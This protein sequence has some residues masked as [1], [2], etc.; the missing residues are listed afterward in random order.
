MIKANRVL[1][2]FYLMVMFVSISIFSALLSTTR[3]I[4]INDHIVN[5]VL[6][7]VSTS[8]AGLIFYLLNPLSLGKVKD[9]LDETYTAS[10]EK[11]ID[12]LVRYPFAILPLTFTTGLA[13]MF[14]YLLAGSSARIIEL[15]GTL[16]SLGGIAVTFLFV[17]IIGEI[18]QIYVFK[19]VTNTSASKAIRKLNV[20]ELKSIYIPIKYKL[21]GVYSIISIAAFIIVAYAV[22]NNA[23]R[24]IK[25]GL[26][27]DTMKSASLIARTIDQNPNADSILKGIAG[28][29]GSTYR[30]YLYNLH[31][32]TLKAYSRATPGSRV[33][34]E[35]NTENMVTDTQNKQ[36]IFS[37]HKPLMIDGSPHLLVI[38]ARDSLYR[39]LLYRFVSNMSIAGIFILFIV[40]ITTFL[41]SNDI[42]S[43]EK[44]LADYSASLSENKLSQTPGLFSTDELGLI[45]LNL[46]T[47]MQTFKESRVRTNENVSGMNGMIGATFKNIAAVRS[48][49][50]EQSKHTDD[51]FGIINSI[52]DIARQIT[53]LS[54]PF[55]E[56]IEKDSETVFHAIQ[57]NRE[58]KST[59]TAASTR[60]TR[61]LKLIEKDVNAYEDMK[62]TINK[63]KTVL[64][65]VDSTTQSY[66]S[67]TD[68]L[69][70][71]LDGFSGIMNDIKKSNGN[72]I[73][74][75]K[76]IEVIVNETQSIAEGVLS[77]LSSF[78]SH[79]QQSDEMLGMINNVAERTNLLS[80]N[81]F[82]LASSPQ[83]EGNNFRVVAEEIKRLAGRART[84]SKD[85]SD[86]ITKVRRNVDEVSSGIKD[87]NGMFTGLKQSMSD[88]NSMTQRTGELS[89]SASDIAA[90][91]IGGITG[92]T[93][94]RNAGADSSLNAHSMEIV[95]KL[96]ED[97]GTTLDSLKGIGR[98]FGQIKD[99]LINLAEINNAH[100]TTLL[101]ISNAV[102]N[103]KTFIG[104]INDSLA[105]D[106]K[107]QVAY[108]SDSAKEL[109][110]HIRNNEQNISDLDTIMN[111][112]IQELDLLKENINLVIV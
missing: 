84:G 21:I 34:K 101:S 98:V 86:Y 109:I 87:I 3:I 15:N 107:E 58:T 33:I 48:T 52:K 100:D 75:T 31:D 89:N 112:L 6:V 40:L 37:L 74:L 17:L 26:Y 57:R 55:R 24:Y 70:K 110:D 80:V 105:I 93:V 64:L 8:I 29:S 83:T 66:T 108:S 65:S 22:F 19:I 1:T 76:D 43:H 42:A 10:S 104:Y 30:I 71:L 20:I 94:R 99:T 103:I 67:D 79:I 97:I 27:N 36:L 62:Y 9:V 106:I 77:L 47:L 49:I 54:V 16:S 73:E 61:T 14:A 13:G 12:M 82:I 46:R 2:I 102:E 32:G 69:N 28:S 5:I 59:V 78:L 45:A 11:H 25:Q 95:S 63:L 81:A 68:A 23:D 88:M 50:T 91:I 38:G 56:R 111:Q 85:I 96:T 51:L 90:Q 7:L 72:G 18:S 35:L 60:I 53:D 41:I 4:T 39:K 92:K 44:K